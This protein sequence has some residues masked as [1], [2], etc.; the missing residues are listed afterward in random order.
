VNALADSEADIAGFK[1]VVDGQ[2]INTFQPNATRNGGSF[3]FTSNQTGRHNLS[4]TVTDLDGRVSKLD[5]VIK[6]RDGAD[7][8]GST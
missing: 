4:I 1:V 6:V 2:E 3:T 7:I 5:R 8:P